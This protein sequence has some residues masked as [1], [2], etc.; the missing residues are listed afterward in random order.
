MVREALDRPET[1]ILPVPSDHF[2]LPAPR[3]RS[4]AIRNLKLQL[5]GL[6]FMPTWQDAVRD[7][8][9]SELTVALR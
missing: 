2:P 4:E 5:L 6:D 8:V 1:E 3:G 9:Q 7:Y